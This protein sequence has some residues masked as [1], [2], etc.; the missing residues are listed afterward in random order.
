MNKRDGAVGVLG[1]RSSVRIAAWS[2]AALASMALLV[3]AIAGRSPGG[4]PTLRPMAASESM[5]DEQ[6]RAVAANTARV[7]MRERN[8]RHLANLEALSC[9]ETH[10]GALAREIGFVRDGAPFQKFEVSAVARFTRDGPV[11]TLDVFQA[12][13][14]GEMFV[15]RVRNSELLVCQVVSAPI[16]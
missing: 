2:V 15:F 3:A 14:G 1:R 7:W 8:E 12:G 10:D 16:P 6:A 9:S 13:G 5:S 11:W 4:G